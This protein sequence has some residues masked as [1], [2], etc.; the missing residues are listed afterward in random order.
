V[1]A[2]LLKTFADY[3]GDHWT[4]EVKQ[5]WIDAYDAITALMLEGANYSQETVRL[6]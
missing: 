6:T 5:A 4:P 2:S 3:L 1:G